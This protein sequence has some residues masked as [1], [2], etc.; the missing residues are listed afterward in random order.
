[1]NTELERCKIGCDIKREHRMTSLDVILSRF[2]E[3]GFIP[4]IQTARK[5]P[6]GL[7]IG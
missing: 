2:F 3:A 6:M 5:I 7:L 1:M 4:D